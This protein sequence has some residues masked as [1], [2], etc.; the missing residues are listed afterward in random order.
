M[1]KK[2][3]LLLLILILI[4]APFIY[5]WIRDVDQLNRVEEQGKCTPFNVEHSAERFSIFL[6]WETDEDCV[7]YAKYSLLASGDSWINV[8]NGEEFVL[9]KEHSVEINDLKPGT[10]YYISIISN[11]EMYGENDSPLMIRTKD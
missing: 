8:L 7:G 6:K 3:K 11:G 9:S 1:S 4:L 5:F 10:D 2:V